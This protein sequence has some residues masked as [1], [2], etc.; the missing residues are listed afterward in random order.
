MKKALFVSMLV[1]ALS[2]SNVAAGSP[3]FFTSQPAMLTTSVAGGS[4]LP[5]ISVG[6]TL[7]N[8]YRFESIPDGIGTVPNA[9]ETVDVFVNHE[10]SLVPFPLAT[11]FASCT[12]TTCQSDFDNAQVSR[13]KLHQVSGGV[14]SGKMMITSAAN[15]QRFCSA[16]LANQSVGF[17]RNIL[18]TNEEA[19]DFVS[20]PPLQAW[21]PDPSNQRQAGLVVALDA[22]NGKTYEIPGLGRMN[23]ENTVIVPGGW[24][25]IVAVTGDDTFSA[26]ASQLYMY[27]ANSGNDVLADKGALYAF[28]VTAKNSVAVDPADPFNGANDYGDIALGDVLQG[29]FIPVPRDVA[30]GDQTA[31]E[32]WSNANNVFQFIR[33]E[34][35][36]YDKNNSHIIYFADTGEPRAL[37]NNLV[38]GRLRRAPSGTLGPYPNGRIFK[39]EFN[40]SDPTV[41]DNFSILI[42]ADLG[43]Y[44]NFGV[45]HNVDNV[46]TSTGSLMITEDPGSHNQSNPGTPGAPPARIWMYNF[47]TGTLSVAAAVDQS[48]DPAARLGAWEA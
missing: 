6:D 33:V 30:V 24:N 8:G 32:N 18:F 28:R 13:L 46:G 15:Y 36:D 21:P 20:P 48:A 26:P 43:G 31:L 42:D 25:K 38:T 17:Q 1:L 22:K 34:D 16:T 40:A 11:N 14:L 39:M 45:P 41:V 44:N 5:I 35:I 29:Q 4:V 3:G 10:T 12:T 9:D 19:T 2:Y 23:H 7:P 47:S 37:D 27:T